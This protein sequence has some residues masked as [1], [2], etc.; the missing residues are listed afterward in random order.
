[1]EK[2]VKSYEEYPEFIEGMKLFADL[3]EECVKCRK[4][5]ED[6]IL[7]I[8]KQVREISDTKDLE[9]KKLRELEEILLSEK[10]RGGD[11]E[12]L[13]DEIKDQVILTSRAEFFLKS[14]AKMSFIS[15]RLIEK[16]IDELDFEKAACKSRLNGLDEAIINKNSIDGIP[17]KK[18]DKKKIAEISK[19]RK[20]INTEITRLDGEI[21]QY[22]DDLKMLKALNPD[23][24]TRI[25][26]GDK[27]LV[28][29]AEICKTKAVEVFRK[30]DKLRNP[31]VSRMES[32]REKIEA[33]KKENLQLEISI[34]ALRPDA[35]SDIL[36]EF[37]A[38]DLV[39]P[40]AIKENFRLSPGGLKYLI[41]ARIIAIAKGYTSA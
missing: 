13:T 21:K 27:K 28:E 15:E 17:I 41:N 34:S 26:I 36:T 39:Y 35:V 38:L 20:E 12:K 14:L 4:S 22:R 23:N 1:M 19:I 9:A 25:P 5:R 29:E 18:Y 6:T 16:K 8:I 24:K 40:E 3:R 11:T 2:E 7:G 31:L 32:N 10:I 33:L 37:N 30:I